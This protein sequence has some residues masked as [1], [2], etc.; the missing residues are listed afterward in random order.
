MMPAVIL[1]LWAATGVIASVNVAAGQTVE[2]G[3]VLLSIEAMKMETA[4]HAEISGVIAQM[5]VLSPLFEYPPYP[6]QA[7]HI[8]DL[9]M[10]LA[11]VAL[12]RATELEN[13]TITEG[14]Y[15]ETKRYKK[16]PKP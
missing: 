3:D 8:A 13:V 14:I 10:G 15:K 5:S 6:N 11:L 1:I 7:V 9:T 2:A 16:S 4:I 12:S